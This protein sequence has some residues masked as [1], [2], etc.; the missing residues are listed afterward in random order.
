MRQTIEQG[1]DAK[2]I[3]RHRLSTG[4]RLRSAIVAVTCPMIWPSLSRTGFLMPLPPASRLFIMFF[5]LLRLILV[6]ALVVSAPL[7]F[8]AAAQGVGQAPAGLVAD[9]QKIIQGLATKADNFE[10]QIQQDGEDD[11]NLVDIRLQLEELSRQSLTS[12]LAF[13]TRLGEI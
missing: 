4:R 7:S 5:R 12:A 2:P 10:K 11:S 1:A 13:R 6:L 8:E 3:L 9:Q